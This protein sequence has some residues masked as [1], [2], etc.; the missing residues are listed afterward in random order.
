MDIQPARTWCNAFVYRWLKV[1]ATG[2]LHRSFAFTVSGNH[3]LPETGPY[4][5]TAN[6]VSFMDPVV[7]QCACAQKIIFFMTERYYKPWWVRWFFRFM[8]CIPLREETHYNISAIRRG[9]QVLNQGKVIGIFPEGGISRNGCLQA[10]RPGSLLL[11]QKTGIPILPAFIN[12]TFQ[13]L[14]REAR[15]IRRAPIC[16]AFGKPLLYET[17]SGGLPGKK[18]LQTA[19]TALM[20][21]IGAL[22]HESA[23]WPT[24]RC[25]PGEVPK[26]LTD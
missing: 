18:G 21:K 24:G 22:A 7:L 10:G 23:P 6:H 9:F 20:E 4:I 15:C 14:P 3:H 13:A 5:V 17:L 26:Q 19:T 8:E 11:A 1:F 25:R 2:I 16:V 12:G